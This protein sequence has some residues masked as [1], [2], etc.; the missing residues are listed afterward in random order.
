[1]NPPDWTTL[2]IF[3]AASELGSV[4]KAAGKCGI[5]VSPATRRIQDLEADL[6]VRL[7]DRS[8]R[9]VTLTAPR[10]GTQSEK[11]VGS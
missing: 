2:R 6:G 10:Q 5:A 3:L 11:S 1:M 7:L 8:V 4:T 9:D